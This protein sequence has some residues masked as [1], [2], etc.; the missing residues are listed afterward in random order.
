MEERTFVNKASMKKWLIGATGILLTS[1]SLMG[2]METIELT[3]SKPKALA[4]VLEHHSGYFPE[5]EYLVRYTNS[6]NPDIDQFDYS[7][8]VMAISLEAKLKSRSV[9]I[10]GLQPLF[11]ALSDFEFYATINRSNPAYVTA[12]V[13]IVE[14]KSPPD[15]EKLKDVLD[16]F[17]IM[18]AF[19][20]GTGFVTLSNARMGRGLR[21]MV[22]V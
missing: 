15:L 14:P 6:D 16:E 21:S 11:K 13:W 12:G 22:Q 5:G 17:A 18:Y 3:F 1:V 20:D 2:S 9:L 10:G 4:A 19:S 8:M 7:K